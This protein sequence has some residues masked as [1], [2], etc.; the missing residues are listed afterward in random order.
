MACAVEY[1]TAGRH[2]STPFQ[3]VMDA[4]SAIRWLRQHAA[5]LNIDTARIVASGNSSGGHLVLTTALAD[6]WNEKT[7]DLSYSATP[8]VLLVNSGV[9]DLT[10][11]ATAWIRKGLADK[12]TVKEISP[13]HSAKKNM[14]PTLLIHGT[15]DRS[16]PY[17]TAKTFE[18]ERKKAGNNFE[19]HTMENASHY[20][21]YERPYSIQV[22]KL[23][24]DFLQKLGY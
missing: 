10:D 12:N 9:Y 7:D 22:T 18:E 11:N 2:G 20:L 6:K 3:S 21:W 14:P 4:R 23:R 19:F 5:E 1:R 17:T 13:N 16:V 24:S 15:K 8:N